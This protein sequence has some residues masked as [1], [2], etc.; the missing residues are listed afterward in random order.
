MKLLGHYRYYGISG[1]LMGIKR[2]Y[3]RVLALVYKWINRRSQRRSY[4][5]KGFA[6]YLEYYPLPKPRI[7]RNLY[8]LAPAK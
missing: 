2:Y 3:L 7:Y 6:H 8:T 5:R 4:N 1:N